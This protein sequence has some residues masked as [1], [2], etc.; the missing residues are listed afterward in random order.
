VT[1]PK[2][3]RPSISII[4]AGRL[5]QALAIALKTSGYAIEGLVARRARKA[6]H[7]LSGGQ[8]AQ[9]PASQLIIIATPD[10]A[11]EDTAR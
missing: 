8:L 7:V 1:K 2:P 4:G 3:S 11:I 5:G 6:E 10:D 9:L